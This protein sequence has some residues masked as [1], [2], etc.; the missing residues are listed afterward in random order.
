[1]YKCC[2]NCANASL[3]AAQ[4][5]EETDRFNASKRFCCALY[6]V[7]NHGENPFKQRYCRQFEGYIYG[8]K[9]GHEITKKEAEKLNMMSVDQLVMY[10]KEGAENG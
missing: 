3:C 10:W 9:F 2:W 4:T 8:A 1:M 7:S 6:P 5:K